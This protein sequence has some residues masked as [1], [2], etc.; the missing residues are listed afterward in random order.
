M[1]PQFPIYIVSKGRADTRITV[2][3]L[4][5]MGV[6]FFIVVE[7]QEFSSYASVIDHRRILVLDKAFQRN[8]QTCDDLGD[9]LSKGSGA[10]RNFAWAHALESGSP[11]Y[12]CIDDNIKGFYRLNYNLK[13]PVS[14][15]TVIRCMEDFV[16]RYRN[17]AMAGPNYFMFASRKTRMPPFV[18]NTRIYSCNL[19]RT[20]LPF[21]WRGRYNED[22]I[23]SLDILKAG[24][25]TILFNAFL[26]YKLPTLSVKGGNTDE[27]YKGGANKLAKAQMLAKVHPDVASVVWKFRRWHHHVDYSRFQMNKLI[28]REVEVPAEADNYGMGLISVPRKSKPRG[29]VVS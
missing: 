15:G 11:W 29:R 1:N 10:A 17:V 20:D 7:E 2:R 24:W 12:W 21:R 6:P 14:D 9:M 18:L 16:L 13:V 4:D 23:L 26:Q 8:Y 28:R 3:H 22:T 27:L 5:E 25:C 19:I